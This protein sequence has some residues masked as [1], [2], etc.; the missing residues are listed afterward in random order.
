MSRFGSLTG[1]GFCGTF[2]SCLYVVLPASELVASHSL[3]SVCSLDVTPCLQKNAA[4]QRVLMGP[5]LSPGAVCVSGTVLSTHRASA[6]EP[7]SI[8][9]TLCDITA[10]S[11]ARKLSHQR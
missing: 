6:I 8:L 7:R 1:G 9:A 11:Q 5:Q 10:I 3:S 4:T 2:V